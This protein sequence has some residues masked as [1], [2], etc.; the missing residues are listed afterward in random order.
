LTGA[1]GSA[2]VQGTYWSFAGEILAPVIAAYVITAA[3]G[4]VADLTGGRVEMLTSTPVTWP[5]LGRGRLMATTVGVAI[6]LLGALT[7]LG[8]GAA[9]VGSPLEPVAVTRL[10]IIGLLFGAALGA[11]A[12]I[13]VALVRRQL[14]VTLMAVL[15]GASYLLAWLVPTLGWPGWVNKFS[16]FWAFGHPYLGWPSATQTLILAVLA[17]A[18]AAAA[19]AI[20]DRTPKVL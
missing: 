18:G 6:I 8:L 12:A 19:G 11:I 20:A 2:S 1:T 16:V 14:A 5:M 7:A 13:T 17:L 9:A 4:W 15:V 10:V 3:S